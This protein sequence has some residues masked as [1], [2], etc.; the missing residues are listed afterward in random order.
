M[1]GVALLGSLFPRGHA[2]AALVFKKTKKNPPANRTPLTAGKYGRRG[3]N[4]ATSTAPKP[5]PPRSTG[6]KQQS[7]ANKAA[8]VEPVARGRSFIAFHLRRPLLEN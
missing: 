1:G 3:A 5:A 7:D 8:S 2:P 6:P 4:V